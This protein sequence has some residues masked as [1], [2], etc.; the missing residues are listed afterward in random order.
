MYPHKISLSEE[1]RPSF[2]I[3]VLPGN[4]PENA[5]DAARQT[6]K[7]YLSV[8][9]ALNKGVMK[10]KIDNSFSPSD[11]RQEKRGNRRETKILD[12]VNMNA[13]LH[14][15]CFF[16]FQGALPETSEYLNETASFRGTHPKS[17]YGS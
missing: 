3:N 2:D 4:L 11:I 10:I 13:F 9:I 5:I 1:I 7:K 6:E 12:H 15:E 14:Y 17:A 16:H 8:H